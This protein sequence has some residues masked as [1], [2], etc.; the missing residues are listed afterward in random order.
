VHLTL[1]WSLPHPPRRMGGGAT[2]ALVATLAV[3]LVAGLA[4]PLPV[5][6]ETT[7]FE[8]LTAPIVRVNIHAGDV[9]IRT[10]DRQS[11]EVTGE[12]T[13]SIV[14]RT[15]HQVPEQT[16]I[17][18]PQAHSGLATLAPET[19]VISSIAPGT[20]D[21]IVV[22]SM[23]DTPAGPVVVTVPNDAALVFVFARGGNLDVRDYRGGTFVG[24]TSRG[25]L[26]LQHVGGTIFA[27][28]GRGALVVDDATT[29]RLRAR[30]L[31]GN[32]TFER[33]RSQQIEATS[34]NGSIVYDDGSFEPGLARFE[35]THGDVAI[36][37]RS[38]AELGAHVAGEGRVFTQ[39]ER[40]ARVNGAQGDANAIVGGGGPVVTATTQ[41]GNIYLFDG[42]LRTRER[43]GNAW[44]RPLA[45]LQRSSGFRRATGPRDLSPIRA[46]PQPLVPDVE[47]APIV[48]PQP[49][50][51]PTRVIPPRHGHRHA[52]RDRPSS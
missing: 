43:L 37:T 33:C 27:Q 3:A 1:P 18:I 29:D 14:H 24:F 12:A 23:P 21:A 5:R 2:L 36:G 15:M 6:A 17:L 32:I 31:Y 16:A 10:W 40:G 47:S 50:V 42:T 48:A 26:A 44:Q 22:K 7:T 45:M 46:F 30:T 52:P 51:A 20:H 4:S 49:H 38:A 28:T 13:L 19:F 39:F 11:V 25:R 9:T 35:S 41:T 34:F 8:G